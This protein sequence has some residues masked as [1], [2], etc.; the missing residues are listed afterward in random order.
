MKKIS[1]IRTEY[2]RHELS[3][4]MVLDDPMEQFQKWLNE[5][6][7]SEVPEP[8]AMALATTSMDGQPSCRMVLLKEITGKGFSFYTHV[9]SRKGKDLK[10][11]PHAALTFW[12]PPLERQVRV[13]GPIE[14]I[15]GKTVEDYFQTRPLESQIGAWASRQSQEIPD[16]GH[17]EQRVM[18]V[19]TQFAGQKVPCPPFWGG[20]LVIPHRIEFWQG[21]PGRLHDRLEYLREEKKWTIRRLAP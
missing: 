7:D 14:K 9:D 1:D 10:K 8:T 2:K 5:A 18:H 13:E 4:S 6:F 20:Y 11:T 12:W 17:L 19:K 15:T 3:K 21:R 16:R